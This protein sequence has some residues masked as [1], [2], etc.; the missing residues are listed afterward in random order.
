MSLKDTKILIPDIPH[1]WEKRTRSGHTN[2]WN[3]KDGAEVKLNPPQRGLFA[4]R[5]EDGWYWVCDCPKC[6]GT[7]DPY[8]YIVCDDHDRCET[9]GVHRDDLQGIT[10][11]GVRAGWQCD[12]CHKKEHEE[13]KAAALEKARER[14]HTEDDCYYTD[15]LI[16]PVCATECSSEELGS[17]EHDVNCYVCDT[18]FTVEIEYEAKY[19]S[20]LKK[21]TAQYDDTTH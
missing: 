6:L 7:D 1:S 14:G 8:P 11:W 10:A 5:F 12:T 21:V 9:C 18:E 4:K 19:T 20:S 2:I 16:C 17:G 3:H 15:T 13:Q